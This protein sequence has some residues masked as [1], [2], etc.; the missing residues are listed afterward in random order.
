ME[1]YDFEN[2][3]KISQTSDTVILNSMQYDKNTRLTHFQ[4]IDNDT[5]SK[6]SEFNSALPDSILNI[7]AT[8]ETNLLL[9]VN[10]KSPTMTNMQVGEQLEMQKE[11]L[12][13]K[14]KADSKDSKWLEDENPT[15]KAMSLEPESINSTSCSENFESLQLVSSSLPVASSQKMSKHSLTKSH[16]PLISV[17][18]SISDG[19]HPNS[20][21]GSV[22]SLVSNIIYGDHGSSSHVDN[23]VKSEDEVDEISLQ[24]IHEI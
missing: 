18:N 7:H 4:T 6:H 16:S 11:K 10:V 23:P 13:G 24:D 15:S 9:E 12:K 5:L 21:I 17:R 2:A 22:I 1:E 3:D 19:S 8:S 14:E 20:K